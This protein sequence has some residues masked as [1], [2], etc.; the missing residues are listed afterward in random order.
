MATAEQIQTMLD[1]MA[2]QMQQMQVLQTENTAL[3]QQAVIV[4]QN[5]G[6]SKRPDRPIDKALQ[7]NGVQEWLWHLRKMDH[8]E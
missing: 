6:K 5:T 4:P 8:Q 1:L 3:R 7:L 2:Q